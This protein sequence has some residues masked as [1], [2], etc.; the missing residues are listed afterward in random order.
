MNFP[1]PVIK[2]REDQ[3]AVAP[4]SVSFGNAMSSVAKIDRAIMSGAPWFPG[5]RVPIQN[6][7]D[8]LEEGIR[9]ENFLAMVV[10]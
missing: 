5:T 8:Y 4:G 10:L 7:I 1:S 9:T 6:L 2:H 3:I